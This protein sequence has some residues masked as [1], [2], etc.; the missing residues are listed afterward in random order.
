[1]KGDRLVSAIV[2]AYNHERFVAETLR[3]LMAQTHQAL[4]LIVLDD[5]SIDA[6]YAR[7][8]ELLPELR[9]RFVRVETATKANEGSAR[10][11]SRCLELARG[12]LVFLLDSDDVAV[13]DAIQRLLPC[14]DAPGVALAVGD[15]EYIDDHG[16]PQPLEKDGELFASLLAFH[17]A[18]R[19]DFSVERDF[20]TYASL[21]GG[22]YVPNGWL[23][24]KRCVAEVGGYAVD[25]VLDDWSLLVR[26]AKRYRI[27][28][29]G[30]V[31]ARYRVHP[32]NTSRVLR[33]R[34][35]LDA[36]RVLLQERDYCVAHRLE[37]EWVGHARRVFGAVSPEQLDRTGFLSVLLFPELDV[38]GLASV[39]TPVS[40][41][42]TVQEGSGV[43]SAKASTPSLAPLLSPPAG[44]VGQR[45][46]LYALCWN[47][48]RML[49]FFFRHYD[50]WVQRYV[51]FDDGSTDGSLEL[52]RAHPRVEV[53]R[54]V[55]AHPESFVLSEL[56][57][58]D[59]CWK[60]SRGT[61]DWVIVTDID[62]HLFH[63]DLAA[64]L[65]KCLEEGVTVVPAI[66]FEMLSEHFPNADELLCRTRR[67]GAPDAA[68]SKLTMFSP[69]A[70]EDI[71]YS[72]GGHVANPVG[73][74]VA[75]ARDEVALLHYKLLGLA[76]STDRHAQLHAR[77]GQTDIDN[78]W[79]HQWI[80]SEAEL[81]KEIQSFRDRLV[82]FSVE[83][84]D[85][86]AQ[87]PVPR[88]WTEFPRARDWS[89]QIAD[90]AQQVTDAANHLGAACARVTA[91]ESSRT[92]RWSG[93]VRRFIDIILR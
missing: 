31:L 81:L 93:P 43:P 7:I 58:Y 64:Y 34:V 72:P 11:I 77:L 67:Q 52:L 12:E 73:R 65:A 76:Y 26:L 87:Y 36:A 60:E 33:E 30:E 63:P 38:K 13:P 35:F 78:A 19:T 27:A 80:A 83:G 89:G 14:L 20:G 50:P 28:Y 5:G 66:G 25:F 3:S 37:P 41:F 42:A 61:A 91:L 68:M 47:D 56:A 8:E 24:R 71:D 6:T 51:I 4:E 49:P 48:A 39:K 86:A 57:H 2:A 32:G 23:L 90:L 44:S 45:I 40:G 54:F 9:R 22:N 62:E 88:W 85:L 29:A 16:R 53:R 1:M 84:E 18:G 92:W 75:P 21:I 59:H 55:R 17:T 82:D 15:N 10:T 74:V 46:H 70:I 69:G 79:G